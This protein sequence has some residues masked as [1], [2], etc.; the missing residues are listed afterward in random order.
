MFSMRRQIRV[1]CAL[2]SAAAIAGCTEP[3]GA[4][5]EPQELAATA[6]VGSSVRALDLGGVEVSLSVPGVASERSLA[7]LA[8]VDAPAE[9]RGVA[10][11]MF[12]AFRSGDGD[13]YVGGEAELRFVWGEGALEGVDIDRVVVLAWRPEAERWVA[14]PL[15]VRSGAERTV[16]AMT[17]RLSTWMLAELA[18][19]QDLE[20]AFEAAI[21]APGWGGADVTWTPT[22]DGAPDGD[23]AIASVQL[24]VDSLLVPLVSGQAVCAT[25]WT[26][27]PGTTTWL[28]ATSPVKFSRFVPIDVPT[29]VSVR[30]FVAPSTACAT[31]VR[32]LFPADGVPRIATQVANACS[33][34]N[35]LDICTPEVLA[36]T[37]NGATSFTNLSSGTVACPGDPAYA[38]TDHDGVKDAC[39]E[40]DEDPTKLVPGDCGCGVPDT[41][42]DTDGIADCLDGCPDDGGKTDPGICGCGVADDDSDSDGTPDCVDDCPADGDKI[43]PGICGCGI[44]D[45]DSDSDGTPDCLDG[46]PD[47]GDKTDPGVCGCGVA[48]DDSD[49]D[50]TPDCNDLCPADGDKIEPGVCGCGIADDDS[51]SDGTPDCNDLCPADGDKIEPGVCGCGVADD[52]SDSDGTADCNDLCPA[53]GDKIE[54]GQCGCGVED[55]DSDSDGTADCNDICWEDPEKTDDGACGCGVA[56][57]V[58]C[59]G[60]PGESVFAALYYYCVDTLAQSTEFCEDMLP[61]SGPLAVPP[62]YDFAEGHRGCCTAPPPVVLLVE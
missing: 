30:Y 19:G 44:A 13:T 48:D 53:D 59:S 9:V 51:D 42:S 3:D 20:T 49:T 60:G 37:I 57:P 24:R 41:D 18:P 16:V 21:D 25:Y 23:K 22:A 54:P 52:D 50:G 35:T 2:A 39:E 10:Q 31:E 56:D 43:A 40:C 34:V 47:D 32:P 38:D 36:G 46:C 14:E 26:G 28:P 6:D 17:D 8:R 62:P 55:T 45:D 33:N 61:C 15:L 7:A 12:S 58:A 5:P 1:V 11:P 4:S 29:P 27:G